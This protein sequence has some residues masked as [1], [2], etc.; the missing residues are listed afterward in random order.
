MP[1]VADLKLPYFLALPTA[2]VRAGVIVILEAT[3][4]TPQL[5][6]VTERLAAQGY[7]AIAPDLFFRTGGPAADPDYRVQLYE[8]DM[9]EML[10]DLAIAATVLKEHGAERVGVTGFCTGGYYTWHAAVHGEGYH[11]AAGFYGSKIATDL[12]RPHCPTLLFFGGQDPYMAPDKIASVAAHH[13]DTIVY[14]DAGHGFMRDGSD[15]FSQE[16]A[17]D[18]WVRL[19]GHFD[20]YLRPHD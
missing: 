17:A 19:I 5:L 10:T 14:P 18:A 1:A 7:A 3:G 20:R 2:P 16:A 12:G 6:R 11:A 9:D 15:D 8:V 4:I 13:P